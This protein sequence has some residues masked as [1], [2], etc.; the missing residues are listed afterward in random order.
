MRFFVDHLFLWSLLLVNCLAVEYNGTKY[1]NE[2]EGFECHKFSALQNCHKILPKVCA[3]R[4][5]ADCTMW[6]KGL[7]P[8]SEPLMETQNAPRTLNSCAVTPIPSS[9][10][11]FKEGHFENGR[12]EKQGCEIDEPSIFEFRKM[13]TGRS[14]IFRG[15]SLVRQI[16]LRLVWYLRGTENI[17]E[18]YFHFNAAYV[19][20]GTHDSLMIDSLYD[21]STSGIINP[22]FIA[23]YVWN[24]ERFVSHEDSRV[25]LS[26]VGYSY[27]DNNSTDTIARMSSSNKTTTM[28]ITMPRTH[29]N[30]EELKKVNDWIE[31]NHAYYLPMSQLFMTHAFGRNRRDSLHFQCGFLAQIDENV[32]YAYKTP[33][34]GDCRDL[35]NLNMVFLVGR[36][37]NSLPCRPTLF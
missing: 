34:N 30:P 25:D 15:N 10:A 11:S 21:A 37:L 5:Q 6:I 31:L 20:N 23:Q 1:S 32:T 22:T 17:I 33:A 8:I 9:C 12:W 18:R 2:Y 13:L 26:V 27:Y 7:L 36:Y 19:T 24:D 16:F 35:M 29:F 3:N 14:I 4:N 28:L